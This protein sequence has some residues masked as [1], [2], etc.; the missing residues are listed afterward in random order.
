MA[1]YGVK[2][3]WYS[4]AKKDGG[5]VTGYSGLKKLGKLTE[6]SFEPNTPD[7]NP[8]YADNQE[9]ETDVSGASGGVFTGSVTH[10]SPED[11]NE[12]YGI[13]PEDV[14]LNSEDGLEEEASVKVIKF[15]GTETA[16]PVGLA[17]IEYEQVDGVRDKFYAIVFRE[18]TAVMP[19]DGATTMGESIEW[20]VRE[21]SFN[22][23]GRDAKNTPWKKVVEC[24][25]E[26]EALAFITKEFKANP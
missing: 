5:V 4:P 8:L 10:V 20:Q 15:T 24:K 19:S 16:V 13:K 25:T 18:A 6:Y 9:A 21:M 23:S 11:Y 7:A 17:I 22:V 26:A 3:I 2:G 14:T 1:V 12:L